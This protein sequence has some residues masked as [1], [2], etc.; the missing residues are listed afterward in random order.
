MA[1]ISAIYGVLFSAINYKIN[2]KF[3]WKIKILIYGR[4]ICHFVLPFLRFINLSLIILRC[5][6]QEETDPMPKQQKMNNILM[7]NV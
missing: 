4:N 7:D 1:N 6:K 3:L 5:K 2:S